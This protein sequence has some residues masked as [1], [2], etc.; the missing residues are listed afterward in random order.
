MRKL[1]IRGALWGKPK[2]G[3]NYIKTRKY[4]FCHSTLDHLPMKTEVQISH[5]WAPLRQRACMLWFIGQTYANNSQN[6]KIC[7]TTLTNRKQGLFYSTHGNIH[8]TLH[9]SNTYN[10]YFASFFYKLRGPSDRFKNQKHL[11]QYIWVQINK[12][13]NIRGF[14]DTFLLIL[15]AILFT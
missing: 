15:D 9:K 1:S 5:A 8:C 10:K 3:F 12:K 7:Q 4:F 14:H 6:R 2:L 13:H 11:N